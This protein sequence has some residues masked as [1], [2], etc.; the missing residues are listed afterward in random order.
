MI[1][2]IV[3]WTLVDPAQAPEFKAL[4]DGCADLVPGMRH[5]DVAIRTEGLE[6][7][8]DVVLVS[9]FDDAAALDA[10]QQ[11]PHHK[12]VGAKLGPMRRTRHVLDFE[13]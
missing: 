5:F 11:H 10:Y 12:A 6:A 7:N 8:A 3:M 9:V 2:H 4:L 1:H 13:R